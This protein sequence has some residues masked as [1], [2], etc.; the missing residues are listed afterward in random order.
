MTTSARNES[1]P[2]EVEDS[3]RA[4]LRSASGDGYPLHATYDGPGSLVNTREVVFV[5]IDTGMPLTHLLPRS[6]V[7]PT[8]FP[9]IDKA[10]VRAMRIL[11]HDADAGDD[12]NARYAALVVT[13]MVA[14]ATS[15]VLPLLVAR[16]LLGAVQ[17]R[18]ERIRELEFTLAQR[19][20]HDQRRAQDAAHQR[21]AR[22]AGAVDRTDV[23]ASGPLS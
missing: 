7:A 20:R 18:D 22:A 12:E 1:A 21:A 2:A 4:T 14:T 23:F 19:E 11:A 17:R 3:T 15:K 16:S 13:C 6:E 5:G 10:D 9:R 8:K